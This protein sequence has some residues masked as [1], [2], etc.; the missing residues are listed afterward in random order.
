MLNTAPK[1]QTESN[2][3]DIVLAIGQHEDCLLCVMQQTAHL[4]RSAWRECFIV[5]SLSRAHGYAPYPA[6]NSKRK[7]GRLP[8]S[9][10]WKSELAFVLMLTPENPTVAE[11]LPR[12]LSISATVEPV[13]FRTPH[14]IIRRLMEG[15]LTL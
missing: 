13:T 9:V 4:L 10:G 6:Y 1:K 8:R 5:S 2:R 7:G 15:L 11:I 3:F 14:H 12:Q